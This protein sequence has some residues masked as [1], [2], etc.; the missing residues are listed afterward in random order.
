[1]KN[2]NKVNSNFIKCP[3][4]ESNSFAHLF[5]KNNEPFV[6]CNNCS[7]V[8]INPRLNYEKIKETYNDEYTRDYAKKATAKS[9]RSLQRVRKVKSRFITSG[10]WL[11]IGCSAGF[12]VKSAKEN[13]FDAFGVDVEPWGI[14]YGKTRLQLE[15]LVSG[16]IEDQNYP[17][18]YFNV[19]SLY[20]VIEH[21]PDLNLLVKEL[22]RILRGNGV[23]HVI[24][25][26]IGHWRVSK[27]L[28]DWKE[29]KPSE[30]LYYFKK[31]TLKKLFNKHGLDIIK[32]D[33]SFKTSLKA[34]IQHSD[35]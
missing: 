14:N 15:N 33:F 27:T 24:T 12:V 30:H 29:I 16:T 13:G 22:K 20:D 17:D 31:V 35:G 34:Y 1:M 26:D 3:I 7:L 32:T 9:K 2:N 19:V 11:D 4:C 25:P 21:V 5:E 10:R 18:N 28:S 6:K 8:L 23:I